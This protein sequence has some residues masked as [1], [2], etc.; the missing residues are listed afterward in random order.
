MQVFGD[1]LAD[2]AVLPVPAA[3]PEGTAAE[4]VLGVGVFRPV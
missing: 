2:L 3:Q 4:A 1:R